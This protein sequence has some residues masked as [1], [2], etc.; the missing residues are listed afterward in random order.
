[1]GAGNTA[2]GNI[3][4]FRN[5]TGTGNTAVGSGALHDT[6]GGQNIALGSSAGFQ[7][8]GND[9]I[10]IGNFGLATDQDT[11]RIGTGHHDTFIAGIFGT[12]STGSQVG[13]DSTGHLGV[14]ATSSARFK[15]EIKPMDKAS[16]A[17]LLLKPVTFPIRKRSIPKGSPSIW[18]RSR[19][20]GKSEPPP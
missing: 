11:I 10:C 4:L 14:L 19:G 6:T 12:T 3:A 1:M 17:I 8:T 15:D 9:N 18:P 16:E 7:I 13:V 5:K 2:V 20:S